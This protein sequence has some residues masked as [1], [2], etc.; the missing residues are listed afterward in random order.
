[1]SVF[2]FHVRD[3]D[4]MVEDPDGAELPDLAAARAKAATAIRQAVSRPSSAGRDLGRRL[5]EIADARGRLLATVAFRDVV[6]LN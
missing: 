6:G 1:M 5:F 2:Y 4:W 3:G